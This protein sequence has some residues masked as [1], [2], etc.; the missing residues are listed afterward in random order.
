[1]RDLVQSEEGMAKWMADKKAIFDAK[2]H[3]E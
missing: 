3:R 2:P 1:M